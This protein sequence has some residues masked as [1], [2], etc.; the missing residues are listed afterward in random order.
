MADF[1]KTNP[2]NIHDRLF[3][4]VVDY[5]EGVYEE[6]ME[7]VTDYE[8]DGRFSPVV[9]QEGVKRWISLTG[10][11]ESKAFERICRELGIHPLTIEDLGAEEQ[12]SQLEDYDSYMVLTLS[13]LEHFEGFG[14]N[15][16]LGLVLGENWLLNTAERESG[17]FRTV[18]RRLQ[19]QHSPL[20]RNG[21]DF[22]LHALLD[23]AIDQAL[24]A[25]SSIGDQVEAMEDNFEKE[26]DDE[27]MA[28]I[29]ELKS[30]L[31]HMH[32]SFWP[33]RNT[34][35]MMGDEQNELISAAVEPY[36]RDITDHILQGLDRIDTYRAMLDSLSD[37]YMNYVSFR[38]NRTMQLL[39]AVSTIFMPLSF[40]TGLYGM[41][42]RYMPELQSRWGYP[43]AVG[44]M[45]L[46]A[47][48]MLIYFKR[49]KLL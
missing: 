44:V 1:E 19:V 29:R 9:L 28:E 20:R 15:E 2:R 11:L 32:K 31:L 39:A 23:T 45:V 30:R 24:D 6:S 16:S 4:R 25:L 21:S 13:G 46:I 35:T 12:R 36:M 22:L 40:I 43:M 10:N 8:G 17:L 48:G 47:G 5:G 7:D 27:T 38:M 18:R 41:N 26:F 3:C 37:H 33:L 14:D 42:F 49:N 34:I